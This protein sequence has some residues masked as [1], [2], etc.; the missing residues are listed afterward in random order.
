MS[1]SKTEQD[2]AKRAAKRFEDAL[3]G[4]SKG[5]EPKRFWYDS[6]WIRKIKLGTIAA[7]LVSAGVFVRGCLDSGNLLRDSG[8]SLELETVEEEDTAP[9]E[10]EDVINEETVWCCTNVSISDS[11]HPPYFW[12]GL[13]PSTPGEIRDWRLGKDGLWYYSR[14]FV[15]GNENASRN[16]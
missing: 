5:E 12:A 7:V 15:K 14:R 3:L 1:L 2:L 6:P 9:T 8:G 11:P 16:D 13:P 10:T 4:G